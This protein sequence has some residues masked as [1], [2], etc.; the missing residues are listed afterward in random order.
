MRNND[1]AA[2]EMMR[3]TFFQ[4]FPQPDDP[5]I[6]IQTDWDDIPEAEKNG[7]IAAFR[8]AYKCGYNKGG[9]D[10]HAAQEQAFKTA[11][12]GTH[13]DYL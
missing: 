5:D 12:T 10:S 9:D 7:W 4:Q 8:F 6:F 1:H 11:R 2:V 3:N 13:Y